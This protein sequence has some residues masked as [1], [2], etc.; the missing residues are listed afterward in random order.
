MV[1]GRDALL[2]T[3]CI[4]AIPLS[5]LLVA[6]A[7]RKRSNLRQDSALKEHRKVTPVVITPTTLTATDTQE[8]IEKNSQHE[9]QRQQQQQ[10]QAPSPVPIAETKAVVGNT[11]TS[12]NNS[13]TT[14]TGSKS[15]DTYASSSSSSSSSPMVRST[16]PS[17][18]PVSVSRKNLEQAEI[19]VSD[20]VEKAGESLKELVI[21]AVKEA[22]DSTKETGKR[23]KGQTIGIMATSDSKDI[24]SLGNNGDTMVGLFEEIM[25]EIRKEGYDDQIKLLERYKGL[26]HAQIKL[27]NARS[28]MA[29]KL[30][31]GS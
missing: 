18:T 26:L 17:D 30:K 8:L 22:K 11:S 28:R 16:I 23:L 21:T 24:R 12:L 4:A 31:P 10:E 25:I 14:S 19:S 29:S 7:L 20:E 2:L 5:A 6:I 3:S 27:V 9:E 13:T 1:R 15:T